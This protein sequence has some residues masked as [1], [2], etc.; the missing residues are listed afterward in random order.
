[1][2]NLRDN[3]DV[4]VVLKGVAT[5]RM[6][7]RV[8]SPEERVRLWPLVVADHKNYAGYQAKTDRQI[9]LVLL[10]PVN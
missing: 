8:A 10:E 2:L 5:Q 7:A 4:D 3:P 1:L 6:R 9:P